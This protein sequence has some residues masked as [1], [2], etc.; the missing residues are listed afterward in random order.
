MTGDQRFPRRLRLLKQ[1]EFERV[2]ANGEC[3]ASDGVF[4]LLACLNQSGYPRLGLAITKKKIKTAVARHK[5]KR[6]IRES[7]RIHKAQLSGL[8]IVAMSNSNAVELQ[9]D[10][11]FTRLHQLWLKLAQRCRK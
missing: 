4:I 3:K 6:L 5:I 9:N 11:C 1:H 2:F 8:D 7:F 10:E